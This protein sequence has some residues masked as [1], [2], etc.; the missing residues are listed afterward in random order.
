MRQRVGFARELVVDPE[1][2][3]MD[4]PLSTL[5]VLTAETLRSDLIDL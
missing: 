3:V 2:L 5:D 1:L 4:E